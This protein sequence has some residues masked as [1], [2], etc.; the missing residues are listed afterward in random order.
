[1]EICTIYRIFLYN[2]EKT[3]SM[4]LYFVRHGES[5]YNVKGLCSWKPGKHVHLT[6]KGREQCEKVAEK[7]KDK[8]IDLIITSELYRAK[9]TAEIINKY[10]D[11]PIEED[12][13]INDRNTGIFEGRPISEYHDFIRGNKF[14]AKPPEGES[15][16]EEKERIIDFL[17]D[18][19]KRDLDVVLAVGHHQ[20]MR[21][22]YG[23]FKG[24][25]DEEMYGKKIKNGEILE[26][27]I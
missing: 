8:K 15:F 6:E 10:H 27:D 14:E 7:L 22:V 12:K 2:T 1:M 16:L 20:P 24:L 9:Q 19:K 25:S 13:R 11:A 5:N 23:Y 18:L 17:E 26:F 21:I 4:K 3:F